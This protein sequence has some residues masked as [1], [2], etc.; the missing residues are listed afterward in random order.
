MNYNTPFTR[1]KESTEL[2]VVDVRDKK[3]NLGLIHEGL[4]RELTIIT[5]RP[6]NIILQDYYNRHL[7]SGV[8]SGKYQLLLVLYALSIDDKPNARAYF[9]GDFFIGGKG[10]YR[11]LATIDSIFE[12]LIE[13]KAIEVNHPA[14]EITQN[15]ISYLL[16]KYGALPYPAAGVVYD[17]AHAIS[18]R[19]DEKAI[20]P[21]YMAGHFKKGIYY[22]VEQ[23]LQNQPTDTPFMLKDTYQA[24]GPRWIVF[25]Y[26]NEKG[27]KDERINEDSFFAIYTGDQW[28][29]SGHPYSVKMTYE[30][31]D[32]YAPLPYKA[33]NY[34]KD[35]AVALGA[36]LA[37]ALIS[38]ADK[39]NGTWGLYKARFVPTT[40]DFT[41][42]KGIIAKP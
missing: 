23:F 37:G 28:Y 16:S 3:E 2:K 21:I 1:P 32:F 30:H 26:I 6:L 14:I 4:D 42:I 20:Y 11:Y 22:N 15:N 34:S 17:E 19:K 33:M 8:T 39:R 5:D 36:G 35:N 24:N 25:N 7:R 27:K 9:N 10:Q 41:P 18:K 29:L 12:R 13:V 31:G 38:A 40:K